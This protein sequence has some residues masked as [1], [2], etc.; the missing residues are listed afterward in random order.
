MNKTNFAYK[1]K[2]LADKNCHSRKYKQI[3]K[4]NIQILTSPQST[5]VDFVY[6]KSK[7]SCG[8]ACSEKLECNMF[9]Y[10]NNNCSLFNRFTGF[11]FDFDKNAYIQEHSFSYLKSC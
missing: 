8:L 7:F 10:A 1:I 5:T 9:S 6:S 2:C 11:A 3:K 4:Q